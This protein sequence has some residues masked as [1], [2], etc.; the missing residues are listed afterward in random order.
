MKIDELALQLV[1]ALEAERGVAVELRVRDATSSRTKKDDFFGF[2]GDRRTVV[3]RV[4]NLPSQYEHDVSLVEGEYERES[5]LREKVQRLYESG[6]F[7]HRIAG[8]FD[9]FYHNHNEPSDAAKTEDMYYENMTKIA[10]VEL[11]LIE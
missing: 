1:K 6:A 2:L 10:E 8:T 3:R 11:A 7:E 4:P 5:D 9:G